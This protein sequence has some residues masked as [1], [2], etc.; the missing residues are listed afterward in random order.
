MKYTV[1]WIPSAKRDLANLWLGAPDR[2]AV[3]TAADSMDMV[4]K[5]D[6]LNH[7]ESRIG[8]LRVLFHAPLAI[9]YEV[10][11]ADLRVTVLA[12]WRPPN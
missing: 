5:Q 9:A 1:V 10:S 8:N 2:Q 3:A 7:G 11:A 12:V 4:L 6:P